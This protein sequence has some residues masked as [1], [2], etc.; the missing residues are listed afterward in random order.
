[1]EELDV[2]DFIADNFS[3]FRGFI[4]N[5][6]QFQKELAERKSQILSGSSNP[7]EILIS[8]L[9]KLN[10]IEKLSNSLPILNNL[11]LIDKEFKL[12]Y[13]GRKAGAQPSVDLL[14][15]N[16]TNF[17][18]AL[19]E[20]KVSH[21]AE[22]QA[23]TELSAYNQGLQN[24]FT[25]LS[26]LEVVWIPISTDWRVTT[27]SAI[28]YQIYWHNIFSVPLHM[29]YSYD[30]KTKIVS[31][32]QIECFNP[33]EEI[34]EVECRNLFSYD[35]FIAF[36]YYVRNEITDRHSFINYV[37]S[38]AS[39]QQI[40]GFIIFHKPVDA[41]FPFGFTIC[42]H[43][44]YKGYLHKKISQNYIEKEGEPAYFEAL[45]ESGIV[46]TEYTDIEF[47]TEKIVGF[48]PSSS[49]KDFLSVGDFA[50]NNENQ[51]INYLFR[52][53][54]EKIDSVEKNSR[55]LG[56][57]DFERHF[58]SLKK[59][60]VEHVIYLGVHSDLIA[61]RILVEHHRKIRNENFF[62]LSQS[63]EYLH[64]IFKEYNL[65]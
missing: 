49:D 19:M 36:D 28:A 56:Y 59:E 45:K 51:N 15:Y 34:K 48:T 23:I 2:R 54:K 25:G 63:F 8:D 10:V 41:M 14:A 65:R 12:L 47:T 61:N 17:T 27:K 58:L 37:T 7:S 13:T 16:A 60:N 31:N 20:L 1:M 11:K 53:L 30:A 50:D 40:N 21:N 9:I 35:C 6:E 52:Q 4:I 57:P 64:N 3:N 42:V 32:F 18:L 29:A 44:P 5:M 24:R 38:I 33:I 43:N 22:R 46:N 26:N 62:S 55:G 39:R